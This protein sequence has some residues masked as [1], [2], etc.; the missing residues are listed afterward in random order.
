VARPDGMRLLRILRRLMLKFLAMALSAAV[1][2]AQSGS[3][4]RPVFKLL[5][6]EE[7][8]SSLRDHNG[9]RSELMDS[10]KYIPF[11]L[12]GWYLTLG[13]EAR[14]RF[15]F[16]DHAVWGRDP[17]D[18]GYWLQRYMLHA[19]AHL[20]PRFRLF[21]QLKSGIE[22]NRKGGPR[23]ADEDQLDVHQAFIDA[24]LWRSGQDELT[25]RVGRQEMAF[26]S[27]R[28]VSFRE[29]PNVRQSFDGARLTMHKAGW[30]VD[31]FATKPVETSRGVFDDSPDHTR[32]FWG[33]Y[34]VRSFP[35]LPK[36]NIDLY[37]LGLDRKR[38]RFDAGLQRE[39]RHSMGARIWGRTESWDYNYELVFQWGRFGSGDIR[40]WTT[41][42]DTGFR[43]DSVRLRPR[44]GLKAD[45]ASGDHD[46]T[47]QTLGTFNALFP[48]GAYFSEADLLG[49]YNLMD[50]H[51]S[52]E[53]T[54]MASLKLT[55]D[56]DFFWRQSI[57]DG[58]Y[59]IPG[60]LLQSGRG[61]TARYIGWHTSAQLEWSINRHLSVTAMYLHF[62]PGDFLKQ[63]PPDR[64][65]NFVST[66][67][68][69]RF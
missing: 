2:M 55:T 13:G 66:W 11:G 50:L 5:R 56:A 62:F 32:S 64:P 65:V 38:A 40:G 49:P 27:S 30:Q 14:Q 53:L 59:G 1:V 35:A 51:P 45:I 16:F 10:L 41:A 26:G 58:I 7:D 12:E 54:L 18:N 67:L 36:G 63:A 39:Q 22:V 47:D 6:Y 43:V 33:V 29:G 23:P 69:Y 20:G 60:N 15:E 44:L 3:T 37:Y 28:L 17:E 4:E 57:H 68:S 19:D 9:S 25:L 46:P 34:G 61:V 8:W 52:I 21:G 31:T 48:K 42:S 24:A